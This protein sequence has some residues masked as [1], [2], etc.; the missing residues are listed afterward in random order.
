MNITIKNTSVI[1]LNTDALVN[2]ANHELRAG[3][4]DCA[5]LFDAAGR[6]QLQEACERLVY[7]DAGTAVI[8]RGYQLSAEYIIHA[9]GPR[10][11]G[12]YHG[13]PQLLYNAYVSALELATA[14]SCRSV[15]F[16]LL[17]TGIFGYPV[18]Q[19]W[20]V[21]LRACRD[22]LAKDSKIEIVFAVKDD[23]ILQIGRN[24]LEELSLQK[25]VNPES[26]PSPDRLP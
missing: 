16:P 17:S 22:F 26:S 19:A 20:R 13:E 23:R 12:G 10:W 4:V 21:A 1:N 6:E 5:A 2:A 7:C 8:T 18:P 14:Y 11:F 25:R 9:V 3:S 24:I 15:G